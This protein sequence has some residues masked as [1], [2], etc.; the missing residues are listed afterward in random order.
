MGDAGAVGWR[1]A[2][3]VARR[4]KA[5]ETIGAS[6]DVQNLNEQLW[7]GSID[8]SSER[9]FVQIVNDRTFSS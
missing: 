9:P 1:G 3:I 2:G 7:I 6:S 5:A 8:L 4:G